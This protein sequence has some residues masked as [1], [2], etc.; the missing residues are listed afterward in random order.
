MDGRF[1]YWRPRPRGIAPLVTSLGTAQEA[2][3]RSVA[4]TVAGPR[5][6]APSS[7]RAER[8]HVRGDRARQCRGV[9]SPLRARGRIGARREIRKGADVTGY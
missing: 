3:N 7:A 1:G 2:P 4:S 9:V 6:Y 8:P 5:R